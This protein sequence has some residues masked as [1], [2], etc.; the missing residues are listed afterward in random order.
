MMRDNQG[1]FVSKHLVIFS[2]FIIFSDNLNCLVALQCICFLIIMVIL[3]SAS[4]VVAVCVCNFVNGII[5]CFCF[6][7][8]SL[9]LLMIYA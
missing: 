7:L 5:E 2:C 9:L 8:S 1:C 6:V 4:F 3:L